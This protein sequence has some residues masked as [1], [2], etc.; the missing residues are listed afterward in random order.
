ME[1]GSGKSR[2]LARIANGCVGYAFFAIVLLGGAYSARAGAADVV[3]ARVECAAS[4]C[5]FVVTL[6]HDDEGWSHYADAWQVLSPDGEVLATRIL[7]HPHVAE[8]PFTRSLHGVEIPAGLTSFRVRAR[9]KVHGLG[10][11]ERIVE[12]P[13]RSPEKSE[14]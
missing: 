2:Q 13:G 9:D 7:R 14:P 10:G 8:Q 12:L 6:R 4:R 3:A 1:Q 11:E 5:S